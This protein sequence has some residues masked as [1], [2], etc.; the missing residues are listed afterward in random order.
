MAL[1]GVLTVTTKGVAVSQSVPKNAEFPVLT[2]TDSPSKEMSSNMSH[3]ED[4]KFKHNR[5]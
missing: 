2:K 5:L 1:A 3:P 4:T